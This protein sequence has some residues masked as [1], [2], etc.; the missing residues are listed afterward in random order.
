L[1]THKGA[2]TALSPQVK[3]VG[4]EHT[5]DPKT[6]VFY[7]EYPNPPKAIRADLVQIALV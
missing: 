1:A 2:P 7:P 6:Q 4:K 5:F 3:E